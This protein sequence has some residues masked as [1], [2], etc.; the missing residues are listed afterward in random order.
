MNARQFEKWLRK[1]HD[2]Q[3]FNKKGTGHKVLV[4]PAN[5]RRSELPMHGGGK[6]LGTGLMHK[7]KKDLGIA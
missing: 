2:I 3:S 5:G 4:N 1:T 7:I 6:Q